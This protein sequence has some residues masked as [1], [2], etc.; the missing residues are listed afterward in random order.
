MTQI[1]NKDLIEKVLECIDITKAT[2]ESFIYCVSKKNDIL[3][4][5]IIL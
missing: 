3:N 1:F 4:T 5:S 2:E